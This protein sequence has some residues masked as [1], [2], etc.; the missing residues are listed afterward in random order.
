MSNY[1]PI[2]KLI[3]SKISG[4]WGSDPVTDNSVRVIRTTNFTNDGELNLKNI[5]RREISENKIKNKKLQFGDIIIEKSGGSP[6]Q[7]VGRVVYFDVNDKNDYLCNNFTSILRPSPEVIPKYLFYGLYY[8]HLTKKT[9]AYQNKTTGIINLQL[10]RYIQSEIIR[11]PSISDQRKIVSTLEKA[12]SLRVKRSDSINLIDEY[13]KSTFLE[14]FGD[15]VTN[16]K[17]WQRLNGDEYAKKISVGVV[18]RPASYYVD[19]GIPALRSQNITKDGISMKNL[20]YFSAED[21]EKKLSKSIIRTNDVLIVRTGQPG[22][23][24]IVP[25]KLDGANCIDV[26]IVKL[27]TEILT[28]EYL[29]TFFNSVGGK[30]IVL[31]TAR[32]QIQQHFNVGALN[33][34]KIPIPSLELQKEFSNI[35]TK[36]KMLKLKMIKQS[37]EMDNQFQALMQKAFN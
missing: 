9:L 22:T 12:I 16:P 23:A 13:L 18:V 29:V 25:K 26:I 27:N 24:A 17:N 28:P 35:F 6:T 20:V 10:D 34:A 37:K 15:P 31:K 11:L 1:V 14:M 36:H 21:N 2:S 19:T 7:P 3:T 4:E 5:A 32:G 8:L 30:D 33:E